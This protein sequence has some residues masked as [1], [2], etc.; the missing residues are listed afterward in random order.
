[1]KRTDM[2]RTET[3]SC[4]RDVKYQSV[5]A[6]ISQLIEHGTFLPGSRIPSVRILSRQ[7]EVSITT[8]MEA[9]RVLEDQGLV[10]ARPQSGYFVRAR[11]MRATPEPEIR[12][13]E[14][15]PTAVQLDEQVTMV[16]RDLQRP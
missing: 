1:M 4:G 8:V 9:Y 10:E 13:P 3:I 7:L 15:N 16:M 5:A 12:R 14:G 2:T 6:R 11:S